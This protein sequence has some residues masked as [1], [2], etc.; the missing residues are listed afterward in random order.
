MK[1]ACG[2]SIVMDRAA[3]YAFV[4]GNKSVICWMVRHPQGA[5]KFGLSRT[6]EICFFGNLNI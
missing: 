4:R 6:Q 5:F 2:V 1:M 3:F